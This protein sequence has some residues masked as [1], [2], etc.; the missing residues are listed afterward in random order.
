MYVNQALAVVIRETVPE[1]LLEHNA[2]LR[3]EVQ[4]LQAALKK[5]KIAK[6]SQCERFEKEYHFPFCFQC[7]VHVPLCWACFKSFCP[8]G[9]HRLY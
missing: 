6:C 8:Q 2:K 5:Y 9:Q 3:S 1:Q 7:Q 4:Q